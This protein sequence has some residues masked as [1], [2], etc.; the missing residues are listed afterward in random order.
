MQQIC[1]IGI[2]RP[3]LCKATGLHNIKM[4]TP[5]LSGASICS[6]QARSCKRSL[7]AKEP[8]CPP[9]DRGIFYRK[10]RMTMALMVRDKKLYRSF[11]SMTAVIALQN[12]ITFAVNLADNVMIGRFSQDA[13]SGVAIVNQ[14]QFLLQMMIGGIGNAIVV[15]GAQYWGK[16]QTGPIK[17]VSA[18]GMRLGLATGLLFNIAVFAAPAPILSLLT[19]EEAVIA[20]GVRYMKIVCFSYVFF[21]LTNVTLAALRSVEE[22][23][24]GFVS[25][26][27]ALVL[28]V[29]LN[30]GL[31]YGNWGM[32]RLGVE[33]AAIATLISRVAES[34]VT[35]V[36]A[37]CMEKKVHL[38]FS[39][40][41]RTDRQMRR[42]YLKSGLPLIASNTIWG[43]AMAVQTA[44]LGRLGSDTIAAN[45]I[46][47]TLFQVISVVL[48]ASANAAG[49]VIGK[50]VGEGNIPLVRSYAKTLQV[51]FLLIGLASGGI[52]LLCRDL[53]LSL[54]VITPETHRI[55]AQFINI[56]SV[57][58]IGSSYQVSCLTG[59][60]TGGGD[61]RFV[62]FNDLFF[63]WV[64]V[65]PSALVSAFV[66]H[67][68]L[69]VTFLCLKSD[70]IL[71]C[72][73]ACIKVN[74]F[75]WI[76]TL[77]RDSAKA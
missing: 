58:C 28:N 10:E 11:F 39:D 14:I 67:A 69:W 43:I 22:V 50:A 52:F 36:Y 62:L 49:V 51:L 53:I 65:I 9:A 24:I 73:P 57:T 63:Q 19:N 27:V 72:I 29:A 21:A 31:I 7:P 15:L 45:S 18:I 35:V 68:P 74:R 34:A 38:R 42:D 59:I 76:R 48:Y 55:A 6:P 12:L 77:T 25:T 41:F 75:R 54:Y 71:K 4:T 5:G 47:T 60:V 13:L 56:L 46:A 3:I 70:Q 66:I 2:L 26:L 17:K 30:Y 20:E 8:R 40:L 37:L 33:G 23:R 61:T 1:W 32:P 64:V 16:R 44:I